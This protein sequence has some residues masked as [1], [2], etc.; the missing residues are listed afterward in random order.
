[1][2][3]H[4]SKIE[5]VKGAVGVVIMLA[6]KAFV[7]VAELVWIPAQEIRYWNEMISGAGGVIGLAIG[8]VAIRNLWR[9]GNLAKEKREY[10]EK[11]KD[12]DG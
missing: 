6:N 10:Y 4:K 11:K 2:I 3:D 12:Q 8:I 7:W 5:L 9:Q 1:M